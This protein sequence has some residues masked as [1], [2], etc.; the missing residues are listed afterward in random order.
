MSSL[1]PYPAAPGG[2]RSLGIECA[3]RVA[4]VGPGV[5]CL[6]VGDDVLGMANDRPASHALTRAGL[7]V[8]KPAG[9]SFAAAAALP[10]AFL[11][12]SYALGDLAWRGAGE[13][14]LIHAAA[15]GVGL[16]ALHLARRVGA[17][18]YATAGSEEKR[19]L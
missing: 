14:I 16:A 4:R 2:F 9:L 3:G 7:L 8:K 1:G 11:T 17:E 15:G 18:V 5:D 6:A 10:V 19:A 13:S 12:A